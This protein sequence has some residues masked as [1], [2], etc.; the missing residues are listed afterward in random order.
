MAVAVA[1]VGS[2]STS[3]HTA[4]RDP[5]AGGEINVLGCDQH[6]FLS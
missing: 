2:I 5:Q 3:P 6:S 4:G 1:V